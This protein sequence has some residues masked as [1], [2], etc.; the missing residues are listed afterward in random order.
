MK[1]TFCIHKFGI[2][3]SILALWLIYSPSAL[4]WGISLDTL[5]AL[6]EQ[7]TLNRMMA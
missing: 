2:V 5:S 6:M 4:A 1:K 7:D 3:I